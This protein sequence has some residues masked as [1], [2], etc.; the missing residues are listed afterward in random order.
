MNTVSPTFRQLLR[1]PVHFLAFGFGS[2]LFAKA[3]GT[4]GTLLGI[5]AWM[6][7]VNLSLVTY[8]IVIVIAALAGIYFCGKTARDLNVHDHSG[9]VW[10]EIVGIWL[11][12]I[13]VPVTWGWIFVSFLLFRFFD[14]LKPWPISWIDKNISGGIGIMADDLLA[15]GFTAIVLYVTMKIL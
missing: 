10:D 8:I 1:N 12:M 3:P 6:F 11:A 7:L 4:A 9:I 5:L 15:G 13:L 14:I 2:G